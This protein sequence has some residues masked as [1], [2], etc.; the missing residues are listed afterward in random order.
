SSARLGTLDFLLLMAWGVF[1]YAYLVTCWQYVAPNEALYNRNYDRLYMIEIL[2]VVSVL[3]HLIRQSS[4][5]WRRF[6]LLYTG[7]ILFNYLWFALENRAIEQ[8]TYFI[9]CWYD[10]PY[11]ASFALFIGVALYG[12]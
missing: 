6:Y 7:A 1:F 3:A 2:V 8:S 4:G 10:S 9:G 11:T 12:R 5:A